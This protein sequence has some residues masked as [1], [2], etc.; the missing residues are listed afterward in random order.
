VGGRRT[1]RALAL[2]LGGGVVV[3]GV[4]LLLLAAW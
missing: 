4:A 3:V 1:G 2:H